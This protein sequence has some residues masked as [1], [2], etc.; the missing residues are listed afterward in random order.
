MLTSAGGYQRE[1]RRGETVL[2]PAAAPPLRWMSSA[3]QLL[4][5]LIPS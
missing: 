4:R 3:A 2:V 5:V 1:F